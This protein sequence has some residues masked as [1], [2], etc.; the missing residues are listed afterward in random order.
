M[1]NN[2]QMTV[3]EISDK[4][5]FDGVMV[6]NTRT[7]NIRTIRICPTEMMLMEAISAGIINPNTDIDYD[8]VMLNKTLFE[9]VS[10]EELETI[11]HKKQVIDT[12][13]N[14]VNIRGIELS[15]Y[16]RNFEESGIYEALTELFKQK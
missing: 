10:N 7:G 8:T 13:V 6:R 11:E 16:R 15:D 12:I 1:K 14:T 2:I 3:V 4:D 5:L 9:L